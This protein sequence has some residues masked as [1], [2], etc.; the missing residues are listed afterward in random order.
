MT[1][2]W[3]GV[4]PAVT[5]KM[6]PDGQVDLD[7]TQRSIERLIKSGVAG[8]IVLPIWERMLR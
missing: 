1:T 2:T 4:F 8:V 5:T 7:A 3:R 6:T